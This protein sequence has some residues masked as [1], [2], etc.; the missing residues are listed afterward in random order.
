MTSRSFQFLPLFPV[1]GY[2]FECHILSFHQVVQQV[3]SFPTSCTLTL[4]FS[5]IILCSND[6]C[7]STCRNHTCL[8]KSITVIIVK[9]RKQH[10]KNK[11]R[12]KITCAKWRHL[13]HSR[14]WRSIWC[15]ADW[16][17]C[18][19]DKRP[20]WLRYDHRIEIHHGRSLPHTSEDVSTELIYHWC[21]TGARH[22]QADCSKPR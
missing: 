5:S 17:I 21:V 18:Q 19:Y 8:Q 22:G 1:F 4:I 10:S 13:P 11:P 6:S 20:S 3:H 15:T 14:S 12:H 16:S 7:L 9:Q 2:L